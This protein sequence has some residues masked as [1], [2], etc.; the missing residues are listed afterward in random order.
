M[1]RGR[2]DVEHAK[3]GKKCCRGFAAPSDSLTVLLFGFGQM[4]L[5]PQSVLHRKFRRRRAHPRDIGIF[6]MQGDVRSQPAV[7]RHMIAPEQLPRLLQ[8]VI[9]C[10][11]GIRIEGNNAPGKVC[12]DSGLQNLLCHALLKHIHIGKRGDAAA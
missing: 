2:R 9:R 5:H 6:R 11:I 12:L 7:V 10:G 1:C 4:Q 8:P 3:I